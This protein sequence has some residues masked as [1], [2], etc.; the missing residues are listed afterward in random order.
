[1]G[2]RLVFQ[3]VRLAGC[4]CGWDYCAALFALFSLVE[5]HAKHLVHTVPAVLL[6]QFEVDKSNLHP[7]RLLSIMSLAWLAW[8]HLPATAA[9]L[10]SRWIAPFVLLG[11]HSLPVFASS[12]LLSLAGEAWFYTHTGWVS[13]VVV[14]GVG[15]LAL[16]A[17]AAWSVW[18]ARQTPTA[19]KVKVSPASTPCGTGACGK[20]RLV[21]VTNAGPEL[22]E[23]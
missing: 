6:V 2:R 21:T 3:S 19:A 20:E 10:R 17:V 11:Q 1:M 13:Q 4:L 7:F 12:V 23:V 15:S 5:S 16:L 18:N 8:R 9:W 14:Q 22:V